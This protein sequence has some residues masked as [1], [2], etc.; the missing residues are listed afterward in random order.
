MGFGLEKISN[1]LDV[2][3]DRSSIRSRKGRASRDAVLRGEASDARAAAPLCA[4]RR[5]K[6]ASYGCLRKPMRTMA[7]CKS[8]LKGPRHSAAKFAVKV[9][10][11]GWIAPLW[12]GDWIAAQQRRTL[13]VWHWSSPF[14]GGVGAELVVVD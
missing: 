10:G 4:A 3:Y 9:R 11:L 7:R 2:F 5:R 6:L 8:G 14:G 13:R 12:I 1:A